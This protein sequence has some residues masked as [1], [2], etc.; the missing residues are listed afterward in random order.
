VPDDDAPELYPIAHSSAYIFL[1]AMITIRDNDHD[2]FD[3]NATEYAE[4]ILRIVQ[5]QPE[6]V[7]TLPAS[8]LEEI[9]P[10]LLDNAPT[11]L[12]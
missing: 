7:L 6:T 2:L 5:A 11:W 4:Q 3:D 8:E 1:A 9:G 12:K 10:V